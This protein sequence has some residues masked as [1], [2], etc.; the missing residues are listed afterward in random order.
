M[1]IADVVAVGFAEEQGV[2]HA[3]VRIGDEHGTR[4]ADRVRG[5]G[6]ARAEDAIANRGDVIDRIDEAGGHE[7]RRD[8]ADHVRMGK[9]PPNRFDQRRCLVCVSQPADRLVD[10]QGVLGRGLAFVRRQGGSELVERL[11]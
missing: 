8:V 2:D 3:H 10:D 5:A 7:S 4:P 6:D 9:T 11:S 1:V